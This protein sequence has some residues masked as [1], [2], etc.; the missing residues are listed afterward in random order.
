MIQSV[1]NVHRQAHHEEKPQAHNLRLISSK[2]I[3][4]WRKHNKFAITER[5]S[6]IYAFLLLQTFSY[7]L[8]WV[9][10]N[11]LSYEFPA[12]CQPLHSFF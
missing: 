9:F 1:R 11:V 10:R 5:I 12:E 6:Y 4:M 7:V 8:R 3:T 2:S